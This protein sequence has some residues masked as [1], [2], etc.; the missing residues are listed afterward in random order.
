M[1]SVPLN[2]HF[3]EM[4]S[5]ELGNY[6]RLI[7]KPLR[8]HLQLRPPHQR[9]SEVKRQSLLYVVTVYVSFILFMVVSNYN[10]V[11]T[12]AR[13]CLKKKKN[14]PGICCKA[15]AHTELVQVQWGG[16]KALSLEKQTVAA[17]RFVPF[18]PR[19]LQSKSAMQTGQVAA[20]ALSAHLFNHVGAI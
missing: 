2:P 5:L 4:R 15:W 3:M 18:S 20:T 16:K 12:F 8:W 11:N 19:L 6:A 14:T 17:L 1:C 10:T 7:F 13:R 9:R